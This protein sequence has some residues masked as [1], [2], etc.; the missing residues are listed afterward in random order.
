M[1]RKERT[2][3]TLALALTAALLL[4]PGAA[5]AGAPE[6][7]PALGAWSDLWTRVLG[8]LGLGDSTGGLSSVRSGSEE[9]PRID[10]DGGPR[11]TGDDGPRID[12]DGGAR[13]STDDG[14]RTDP[15]G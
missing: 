15:N 9:G 11:T 12:P 8:W 5:Q 3:I 1:S 13:A 4:S 7:P 10:P 14:P 6:A 2:G